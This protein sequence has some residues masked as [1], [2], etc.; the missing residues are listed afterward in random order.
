MLEKERFLAIKRLASKIR[1]DNE[2]F[3]KSLEGETTE[4]AIREKEEFIEKAIDSMGIDFEDGEQGREE[5]QL[6]RANILLPDDEAFYKAYSKDKNIRNL[7]NKFAV[8][9]EDIMSKITELNIYGDYE[10]DTDFVDEMMDISSK[11]AASLLEEIEDL[12]NVMADLNISADEDE[13]IPSDDI[14]ED[15]K[16]E[17]T[18]ITEEV[19]PEKPKKVEVKEE[20]DFENMSS[21]VSDFVDEYNNLQTDLDKSRKELDRSKKEIEGALDKVTKLEKENDTLKKNNLD[22]VNELNKT[23]DAKNRLEAENVKLKD[24]IK[25]LESK[26]KQSSALLNKIYKS[27]SKTRK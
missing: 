26:L 9:I 12:S 8:G 4:E 13:K 16:V 19:E 14:K 18:E 17:P 5:R 24:N 3:F 10:N 15:D 27:L 7:M 6:F 25:E 2:K 22:A 23:K 11:E 21:V 20:D 1:K